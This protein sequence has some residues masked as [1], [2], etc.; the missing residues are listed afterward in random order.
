VVGLLNKVFQYLILKLSHERLVNLEID[1]AM[2]EV[3]LKTECHLDE[4][5]SFGQLLLLNLEY[6]LQ[7]FIACLIL[8]CL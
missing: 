6:F 1:E 8:L 3:S 4:I 2:T 5:L 7:E